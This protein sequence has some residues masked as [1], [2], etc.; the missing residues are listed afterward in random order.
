MPAILPEVKTPVKYLTI[1]ALIV[2][3]LV[4]EPA[5]DLRNRNLSPVPGSV[6]ERSVPAP[7][8]G[9]QKSGIP[10][11]HE[12]PATGKFGGIETQYSTWIVVPAGRII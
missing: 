9:V 7:A 12:V 5:N 11:D 4:I 2:D 10:I 3:A 8:T 6:M 1:Y